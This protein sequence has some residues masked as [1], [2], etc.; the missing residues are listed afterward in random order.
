M[1]LFHPLFFRVSLVELLPAFYFFF[2]KSKAQQ[3]GL[4]VIQSHSQKQLLPNTNPEAPSP[5][6]D[7]SFFPCLLLASRPNASAAAPL[8]TGP[9]APAGAPAPG[10]RCLDGPDPAVVPASATSRPRQPRPRCRGRNVRVRRPWPLRQCSSSS[11]SL[12]LA[13]SATASSP[14][15][16][17]SLPA[18]L[19]EIHHPPWLL[20]DDWHD[21]WIKASSPLPRLLAEGRRG[22]GSSAAP[23]HGAHRRLQVGSAPKPQ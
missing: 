10:C 19:P 8:F 13:P 15:L 4:V 17:L 14:V 18:R 1:F 23:S 3:N 20:V 12:V 21:C 7:L 11:S 6:Y 16:L 9:G 2:Q 5:R 22:R